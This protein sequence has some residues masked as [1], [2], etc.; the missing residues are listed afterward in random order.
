MPGPDTLPPWP[1]GFDLQ[2]D[3]VLQSAS[4]DHPISA[5]PLRP[6]DP[7]AQEA[8]ELLKSGYRAGQVAGIAA[9]EAQWRFAH[10]RHPSNLWLARGLNRVA[11][12]LLEQRIPRRWRRFQHHQPVLAVLIPGELRCLSRSGPLLKQLGRI[13]DL[14]ITTTSGFRSEAIALQPQDLQVIEDDPQLVEA[15]RDLPVGS[16]RQW[17]KLAACCRQMRA[18]ERRR[19]RPYRWAVKWRTDFYL[20]EPHQ[21]LQELGE[22]DRDPDPGLIGASDKLFAGHRDLMLRLEGFW[23][24]L[25]G[26]FLDLDS[27]K[28]PVHLETI[29]RGDQSAKWYGFGLP[30]RLVGQ[31]ASVP[32]LRHTLQ[33]GGSDLARALS[34]PWLPDEPLVNFFPGHPRFPSEVVFARFLNQLLIPMRE[35]RALRGFLYSDRSHCQ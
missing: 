4:A 9:A 14:F 30:E 33:L 25:Q 11:P 7:I 18:A 15:E 35:S 13:A 16:M 19:G 26:Q 23:H 32:E 29:L 22:L 17:H 24:A 21:L 8:A 6:M 20:L 12:H 3:W 27:R 28:S 31:P 1:R 2:P 5:N 34:E 10:R